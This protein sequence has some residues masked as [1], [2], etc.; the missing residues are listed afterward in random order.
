[1]GLKPELGY[2]WQ[3]NTI[4]GNPTG[5]HIVDSIDGERYTSIHH[6]QQAMGGGCFISLYRLELPD[7]DQRRL[8][9]WL[10]DMDINGC[11]SECL[12]ERT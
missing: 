12:D 5:E 9:T 1:M 3:V 6:A 7:E 2:Y 8:S 11:V 10:L 4:L